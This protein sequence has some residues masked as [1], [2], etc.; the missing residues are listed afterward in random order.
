MLM[1]MT[2]RLG[3]RYAWAGVHGDGRWAKNE[4]PKK[5]QGSAKCLPPDARADDAPPRLTRLVFRPPFIPSGLLLAPYIPLTLASLIKLTIRL[6]TE[7][8]YF[9]N[10]FVRDADL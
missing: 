2:E 8:S 1:T 7:G 3:F 6:D 5:N 4:S 9:P 10:R